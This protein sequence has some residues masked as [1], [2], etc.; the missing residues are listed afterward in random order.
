M[1]NAWGALLVFAAVFLLH[2]DNALLGWDSYATI[3]A[4][5]IESWASF[6]K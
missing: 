5:R 6:R 4:G 2:L 1:V 3:I